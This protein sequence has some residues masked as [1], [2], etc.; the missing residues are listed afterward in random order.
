MRIDLN[1]ESRP[2]KHRPYWLN[3]QVKE[4]EKKEIDS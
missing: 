4:K 1:T 2:V 3:P